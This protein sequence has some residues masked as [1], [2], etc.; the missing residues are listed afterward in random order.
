MGVLRHN[1]AGG[2]VISASHNPAQW[3]A[4]KLLNSRSEFLDAEQGARVM[5][6]ANSA[7]GTGL[8]GLRRYRTGGAR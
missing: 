8:C 6:I 2:I 5:E 3:N 4:L 1:A 7:G